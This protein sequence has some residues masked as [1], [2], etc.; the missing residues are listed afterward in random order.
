MPHTTVV[1]DG[2]MNWDGGV[3][4]NAI[5]TIA[6][7]RNPNG[8]KRNQLAWAN[9]CTVRDGGISPRA[10]YQYLGQIHDH[11]GLFQGWFCYEPLVGD[12]YLIVAI[13]G[14]IYQVTCTTPPQVTNLS[15][16]FALTM[17]ATLD[18][19]YFVQG[20]EYLV[21][22][23]GDLVTLPLFWNGAILRR[24]LGITTSAVGPGTPNVNEIPAATAMDYYQGRI[25]YAQGTIRCAGDIIGGNSGA[26]TPGQRG[27][28]LN[29]TESPLIV[30]GDGFP[31]PD[32]SGNIRALTHNANI[33][34]Q[35]GQGQ[36]IAGTRK[37]VAALQVPVT[38]ADWIATTSNNQPEQALLQLVNGPVNDRS[39]T[40]MNGDIYFNSFEP[41]IRSLFTSVRNWS[42]PGNISI[43]AQED[44]L[45]QFND[46]AFLRFTSGVVWDNRLLMTELPKQVPQGVVCPAVAPLD[47]LPIST[48]GGQM[49]PIWEGVREGPQILQFASG[50]FGGLERAFA[51]VVSTLDGTIE[52]WELTKAGRFDINR[53]GESRITWVS[54]FPAFTWGDEDSLKRLRAGEIGVDRV[55]GEVIVKVEYRQDS[56]TCWLP[57]TEFKF[58][59]ARNSTESV[60]E[61]SVY[62]LAE[63]GD[64]YRSS[65]MLPEPPVTCSPCGNHRPSNV[66]FQF[67]PR[68][69]IKGSCRIRRLILWAEPIERALGD[70]LIC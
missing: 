58:C 3:D 33:N 39:M 1:A 60:G 32:Q 56:Q 46:R 6:S 53:S 48:L 28:I 68:I 12:P 43:S 4:S 44:R 18:Y 41:S 9:N 24:S 36:L 21:I 54:E 63:F 70:G 67:Q 51:C 66:A 64:C 19:F 57:W 25:W 16:I 20:A 35:L 40:K 69:T 29:V 65:L 22:Q 42:Q 52:L 7:E 27:A 8:L 59:S 14:Q 11:T 38:R 62:P 49:Q 10:A 45:L 31:M 50:D 2:S 55:F 15:A 37:V 26:G 47:F 61:P 17:P 5:T 30:G 23:A 34:N 13:S